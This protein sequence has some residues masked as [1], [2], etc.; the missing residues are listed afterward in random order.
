MEYALYPHKGTWKEAL[1]VQRGYELNFP[2]LPFKNEIHKGVLPE[3]HSF[4]KLAPSNLMLTTVKKAEDSDAW[5]LQ[6]SEAKGED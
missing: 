5:V 1:T 2:F 6:W 4:M 3:A